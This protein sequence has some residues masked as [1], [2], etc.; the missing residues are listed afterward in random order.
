MEAVIWRQGN[1]FLYRSIF[2]LLGSLLLFLFRLPR[3]GLIYETG[4]LFL[5]LLVPRLF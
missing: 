5:S 4:G 3:H 1:Q 2:D